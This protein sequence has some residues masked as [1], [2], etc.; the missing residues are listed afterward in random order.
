MAVERVVAIIQA[1]MGS[2]RLPG[3]V[4]ADLGDGRS[5]LAHVIERAYAIRG[6]DHVVVATTD[7]PEDEAVFVVAEEEG[8]TAFKGHATDVLDRYREAASH[9]EAEI[10]LR[11]TADCPFL[12]PVLATRVLVTLLA[13]RLQDPSVHFAHNV[14][15]L[16]TYPDGLDIEVFSVALLEAA[17]LAATAPAD[18]EH[19]TPKMRELARGVTVSQ[20][21]TRGHW[22]WT[23]D[24]PSDLVWARQVQAALPPEAY[25]Q[26][27]TVE[28]IRVSS[29][30]FRVAGDEKGA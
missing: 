17:W 19:V 12:D 4:L 16:R 10:I 27:D 23:V 1:R 2:S 9:A 22:R 25:T 13:A 11:I 24:V 20:V 26:A 8:A 18:R 21:E 14:Q 28:A 3:K 15:E 6:V 30:G 5:L 29:A 7:R